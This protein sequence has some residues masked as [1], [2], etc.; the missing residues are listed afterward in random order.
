MII[1]YLISIIALSCN[2]EQKIK[3][4]TN[5]II[6]NDDVIAEKELSEEAKEKYVQYLAELNSDE[7][8]KLLNINKNYANLKLK[9]GSLK[10]LN[11]L[12]VLI[13]SYKENNNLEI[14][15]MII[16]LL[17]EKGI[18]IEYEMPVGG[19]LLTPITYASFKNVVPIIKKLK[20]KGVNLNCQK[21]SNSRTPLMFALMQNKKDA[22]DELLKYDEVI[23]NM[24]TLKDISGK[25]ASDFYQEKYQEKNNYTTLEEYKNN[26]NKTQ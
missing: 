3:K 23:E 13:A 16:D 12:G 22:V 17:I 10:N 15:N 5:N 14:L 26:I 6:M 25:N 24:N 2:N 9:Y 11:P 4:N 1:L 20:E 19:L 8:N 18:N 21:S 7:I